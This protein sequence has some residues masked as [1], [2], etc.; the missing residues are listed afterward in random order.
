MNT[1][2]FSKTPAVTVLNNRG[3]T[4]LNVAYH[5]HPESPDITTERITRH[6]YDTRG[7]L[8]QS[9][10]PRLAGAGL[11]NFTYRT[12]LRGN[13][14][15]TQ[16][17][18]NGTTVSLNDVAGRP[19]MMVSNIGTAGNG[20]DD[21]RQAVTRTWQYEDTSL[22]GRPLSITE[23][24]NGGAARIT[25][26]FV[27]AGNTDAE[28]ALN[29]AGQLVSHYDTAG[30][31][32]TDSIALTGVPLSVT[33][34]MLKNADN[35]NTVADWQGENAPAWNSLL[36]NDARTTLTTTDT[37]GSVL[38]TTDAQGNT[39]RMAYDVAGLLSGSRLTLKD[40]SEKV[41]VAS[42][43]Y[44]AAGQKLRE[45][46]G[47]GVITT[48]S[49]EPETQR[50]NGIKTERPAGHAAGLKIL[51]DLRYEYDPVGNVL[52]VTN[53]AEETR[54]WRNQK[55]VPENTYAYD[56]LYQLISATGREMANAGQQGCGLPPLTVP[57]PAD[58]STYTN[59][60]RTYTYDTA[61]NLTQISHRSPAANNSYTTKITISNRSNRGV[62]S[63][64]T[65]NPADVD[66]LFTT[67]GQQKQ[68]QPGQSLTWT[69][70]NTLLK[71]TPIVRDGE[72]DDSEIYRYDAG[73]RRILKVS[74]QKT[75]GSIQTQRVQYL[76]GLELHTT[77]TGDTQTENL[78]VIIA[79]DAG[80]VR[81]LHREN[82]DDQ[83]RRSY[84]NL[85]GSSGL[86]LDGEGNI[87]SMEEYYPYGGTAVWTA[88]SV[89]EAKYKTVRYSGRERDATGL[90]YYGY[91]YYQPWA[92]RWLSADPAG[93]MDGLNLFRMV[94]NNPLRFF[95]TNGLAPSD[96]KS[97]QA[98]GRPYIKEAKYLAAEQ[99][100]AAEK[101]LNNASDNDVALDIYKTFFGQHMGEEKLGLWKTQIKSVSEGINKL[102][103]KRNV[104]YSPL[105]IT[106]SGEKSETIAAEANM[107]AFQRGE[108][109]YIDAYTGVLEKVKKNET[110]GVDHLAHILIHEMSHLRLDTEDMAYIGVA[111]NE[112]YHD[113]NAMLALL[114]P[115]KLQT[116]RGEPEE[117]L[118]Q[119]RARGSLDAVRNAD[120]FTTATRYLAY[121]AKNADF[122]RHFAGQKKTFTHGASS[123]ITSQRWR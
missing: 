120:S 11:T 26:R 49:Y 10:D 78:Q 109:I 6:L 19:F 35:A 103:T 22:A 39:Q 110:L 31:K 118:K 72:A 66:A 53:D 15:R 60:T 41:I 96:D 92:G 46:H 2:L 50:L 111:K 59:Y 64:L 113:L 116:G 99:L 62:L 102:D 45:E 104:R 83:M 5:R 57:L 107:Q 20:T 89:A 108:K 75:G 56:S 106:A 29:L 119:R 70:R 43:T 1:S 114:E 65:E 101:F 81:L 88:R 67:G 121:T 117:T 40:G 38:T 33:R 8:T 21:R 51:Q 105:K 97:Q 32:Q 68:L 123:L 16:G 12:D 34:R 61:G 47:N 76:P 77:K 115:E 69:P 87:I 7:F 86:E 23:Q 74:R 24:V 112:G 82:D 9:A 63:T 18:D 42:L 52:K 28:K 30:L 85:I 13:V 94:R 73:S 55:V 90:Y 122:Y 37:T 79:G 54:F 27:Y 48:Y 93:I 36:D 14:L 100:S 3:L 84:D 80:Q 71:V 58:S 17:T 4:I 44:S 95:D 91:R 98:L 25:E